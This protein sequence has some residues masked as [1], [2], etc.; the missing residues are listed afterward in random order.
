[1]I[2][3]SNN[4]GFNLTVILENPSFFVALKMVEYTDT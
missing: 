2:I 4:K 1:M 3:P